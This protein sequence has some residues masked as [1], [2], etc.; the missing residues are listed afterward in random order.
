MK[1]CTN[2]CRSGF[3]KASEEKKKRCPRT[4]S[5]SCSFGQ[6]YCPSA[7]S[8]LAA[9]YAPVRTSQALKQQILANAYGECLKRAGIL[10]EHQWTAGQYGAFCIQMAGRSRPEGRCQDSSACCR[11]SAANQD[12]KEICKAAWNQKKKKKMRLDPGDDPAAKGN[13]EQTPESGI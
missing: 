2:G 11:A 1:S 7:K 4:G 13:R 6:V 5:W 9:D 8:V 12:Q 3:R 10:F